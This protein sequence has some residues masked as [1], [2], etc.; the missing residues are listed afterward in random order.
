MMRLLVVF[1]L[2]ASS[3]IAEDVPIGEDVD[4]RSTE[5]RINQC[6]ERCVD[7]LWETVAECPMD[8]GA[9]ACNLAAQA[10]SYAC[11]ADCQEQHDE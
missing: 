5:E 11:T 2:A 8:D 4:I 10:I 7:A 1:L 3:S 6:E 9:A